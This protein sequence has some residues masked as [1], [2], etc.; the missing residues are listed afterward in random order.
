MIYSLCMLE[1]APFCLRQR[2]NGRNITTFCPP[3]P[4]STMKYQVALLAAALSGASAFVP[5]NPSPFGVAT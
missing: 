2:Q 3:Y 1:Y 4:I 5:S